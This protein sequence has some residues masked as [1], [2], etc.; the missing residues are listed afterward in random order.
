MYICTCILN[1]GY[2]LSILHGFESSFRLRF[3]S[4]S[5]FSSFIIV[6]TWL[7]M[8]I[9]I[10]GSAGYVVILQ[11]SPILLAAFE[12]NLISLLLNKM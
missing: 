2:E 12:V 6:L 4:L 5:D 8:Y 3:V 10:T 9:H 1:M 7:Y 11:F